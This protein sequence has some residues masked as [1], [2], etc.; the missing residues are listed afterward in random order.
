[1]E[2]VREYDKNVPDVW[3]DS[4]KIQQVFF[5]IMKNSIQAMIRSES[6]H[7]KLYFRSSVDGAFVCIE[8]EDN[9]PGIDE[10]VRKRIFEPFFTTQPVGNG[11]G[12]G[13]SVS[14]F[15]INEDH[16]GTITVE[17]IPDMGTRFI[18]HLP[19]DATR[20]NQPG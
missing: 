12:L 15:I 8:I 19:L 10:S 5:S 13:L 2:V 11:S 18:L 20:K 4:A 16:K 9:G 17:S 14:Y 7:P 6:S 3:C 1:M